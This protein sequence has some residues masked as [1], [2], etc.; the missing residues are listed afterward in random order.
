MSS[1]K[2]SSPKFG[3]IPKLVNLKTPVLPIPSIPAL[4][5]QDTSYTW[6]TAYGLNNNRHAVL[7]RQGVP[8]FLD[9]LFE[10]SGFQAPKNS[11]AAKSVYLHQREPRRVG[12]IGSQDQL[13][14][15][16]CHGKPS[17]AWVVGSP[18]WQRVAQQTDLPSVAILAEDIL[19]WRGKL[20]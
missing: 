10:Q 12:A 2:A 20:T 6:L 13:G 3:G 5:R 8:A 4:C 19:Y 14:L 9:I 16:M 11:P 15:C 7:V 1:V 17:R 18:N